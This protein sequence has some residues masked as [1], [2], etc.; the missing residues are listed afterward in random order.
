LNIPPTKPLPADRVSVRVSEREGEEDITRSMNRERS[1][2]NDGV[3]NDLND[4]D[5]SGVGPSRR[6]I[7]RL[8]VRSM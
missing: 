1:R 4:E 6:H 5:E 8:A 3:I 2:N 7:S